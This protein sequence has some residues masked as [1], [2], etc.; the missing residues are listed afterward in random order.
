MQQFRIRCSAIGQI[1]TEPKG[2]NY[3]QKYVDGVAELKRLKELQAG[4][5]DANTKTA[6]ERAL[7]IDTLERVDLPILE[8]Q[9]DKICLSETCLSYVEKWIKEQP[10]FYGRSKQFTSKYTDKGNLCENDAIDFCAEQYGWGMVEKNKK[11]FTDDEHIIGTPDIILAKSVEDTK[12]SWDSDTFP[13]FD[14]TPE[15]NYEWQGHGYKAI[16]N[17]PLFGLHYCLMD[18]PESIVTAE[19][20]K[21]AKRLGMTELDADLYDEVK[22]HMTYS[23]LPVKLRLKSWFFER[24]AVAELAIRERVELVRKY[25]KTLNLN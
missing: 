25:I 6:V 18:A 17:K 15:K 1:M 8:A 5:K 10:E 16:V 7:K 12:V 13:L 24:N 23:H 3:M 19:A 9:K 21:E 20:W 11:H 2:G 22:A 4:V 14:V